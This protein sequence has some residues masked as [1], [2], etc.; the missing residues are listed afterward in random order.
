M[1]HYCKSLDLLYSDRKTSS[2]LYICFHKKIIHYINI[3]I[4]SYIY[5]LYMV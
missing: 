1:V 3:S 4:Y 2:Y 5:L